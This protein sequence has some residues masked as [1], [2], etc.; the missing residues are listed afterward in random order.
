MLRSHLVLLSLLF[1]PSLSLAA[2]STVTVLNATPSTASVGSPVSLLATVNGSSVGPTRPTGTVTFYDGTNAVGTS[3]LTASSITSPATS[4]LASVLGTIDPS[5][6]GTL[7]TADLNGD[8]KTDVISYGTAAYQVFLNAGNGTYTARPVQSYTLSQPVFL[9]ANN[10]GKT[11]IIS[12]GGTALN[13][14]LGNG[15]GSFGAPSAIAGITP[16]ADYI[17]RASFMSL[18]V[19]DLAHTG[20]PYLL[21]GDHM[22]V[23][24]STSINN[25]VATYRSNGD[26]TF[27]SIG[28][29]ILSDVGVPYPNT[30]PVIQT[31][32]LNGDGKLDAVVSMQGRAL[33]PQFAY[34]LLGNGDGSFGTPSATLSPVSCSTSCGGLSIVT[35]DFNVDGKTDIA[36]TSGSDYG[37]SFKDLYVYAGNGDG[38]FAAPVISSTV[39]AGSL[40]LGVDNGYF[41]QI[42]AEDIDADGK[43]DLVDSMGYAYLSNGNLTFTPT[44]NLAGRTWTFSSAQIKSQI[45]LADFNADGIQDFYVSLPGATSVVTAATPTVVFGAAGSVATLSLPTLSSGTH[46]LTAK[47]NGSGTFTMSTSSA[48]SVTISKQTPTITGTS[49]PNPALTTQP[50]TFN[51]KVTGPGIAPTGMVTFMGGTVTLGTATLDSG[52][53]ASIAYTFGTV[54]AQSVTANYAGDA[55][56]ASGSV[57]IAATTVNAFTATPSSGNTTLTTSLGGSATSAIVVASQNSFSGSVA[58]TCTGLPSGAT[59]AFQPATVSVTPTA[60]GNTTLTVSVGQTVSQ[61]NGLSFHGSHGIFLAGVLCVFAVAGARRRSLLTG[62]TLFLLAASLTAIGLA[63]C[64]GGSGSSGSSTTAKSYSFNVVATSGTTQTTTAYTLNVQ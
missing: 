13:L 27:T 33:L 52:G 7:V 59:C 16:H 58:F 56:T 41:A 5:A 60:S 46:S 38:T 57:V 42:A 18:A 50:V 21:V 51:V 44:A 34:I 23:S 35:G 28:S 39:S 53:N 9:D 49:S 31:A 24:G 40:G 10:D 63:G 48:V 43:L 17:G 25:V 55:N 3:A 29:Y 47:Y 15:A 6:Q 8:G 64:S 22:P 2:Q 20:T 45:V 12:N 61:A 54:G 36:L 37:K 4:P 62:S 11:D 32:D 30:V 19:A 14:L 1:S 26:G